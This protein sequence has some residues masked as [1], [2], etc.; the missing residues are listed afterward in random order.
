[1]SEPIKIIPNKV[2]TGAIAIL[3]GEYVSFFSVKLPEIPPSKLEKILPG[4]MAD[5]VAGD[6]NEMHLSLIEK[7]SDGEH[8][9]AVC[10]HTWLEMAK[11]AAL[12]ENKI[13]KAIWPD[14]A[15]LEVPDQDVA[16]MQ[17]SGRV[18]ARRANGTGFNVKQEYLTHVI[19]DQ[20]YSEVYESRIVPNGVG[21]ASGKYSARPPVL[22]YLQALKRVGVL[23]AIGFLTWVL[24]S[25]LTINHYE[26]ERDRYQNASV[27]V[28]KQTYP[29]VTRIVNPEAQ[30]RALLSQGGGEGGTAYIPIAE[31]VFKVVGESAGVR[32]ESLSFDTSSIAGPRVDIT[33][34]SPSYAQA[35]LF[36]SKLLES[37]F[38]VSQ[39]ESTQSE[40]NI[41]SSYALQENKN[42]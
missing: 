28:F 6:V 5:Y 18:L 11:T 9:V 16:I 41:L 22:R 2:Q 17:L 39:G 7:K 30:M 26:Q 8:L 4:V 33:I 14:Y 27:D 32:L 37:G 12:K 21:L 20:P 34:S 29:N 31:R 1:M 13:L 25:L 36:E 42:E 24:V 19:G 23:A 38:M 15:L 35:N 3:P 10:D 40:D